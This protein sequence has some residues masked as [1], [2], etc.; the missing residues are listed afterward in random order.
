MWLQPRTWICSK[1]CT[2]CVFMFLKKW[3]STKVTIKDPS[4]YS[5]TIS[6]DTTPQQLCWN[7]YGAQ[8]SVH[9][10]SQVLNP[11]SLEVNLCNLNRWEHGSWDLPLHV[12]VP[13]PKSQVWHGCLHGNTFWRWGLGVM[14]SRK[15]DST[16]NTSPENSFAQIYQD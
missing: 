15:L 3:A 14:S 10:K 11:E 13:S 12:G 5:T 9:I 4:T 1:L 7:V 8:G 2:D 16:L 6:P